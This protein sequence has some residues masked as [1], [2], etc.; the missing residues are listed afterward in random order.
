M[1]AW[2][3]M[4]IEIE[5]FIGRSKECMHKARKKGVFNYV[6]GRSVL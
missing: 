1:Y 4:T 3:I 2:T 5:G 6:H